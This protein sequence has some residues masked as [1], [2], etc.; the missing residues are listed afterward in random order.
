M[1]LIVFF[2]TLSAYIL[3]PFPSLHGKGGVALHKSKPQKQPRLVSNPELWRSLSE[4]L[5]FQQIC[6]NCNSAPERGGWNWSLKESST[7]QP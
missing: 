6:G 1:R 4:I 7:F 5:T 2:P 3:N